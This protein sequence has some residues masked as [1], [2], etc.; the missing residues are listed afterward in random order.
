MLPDTT[1]AYDGVLMGM[2]DRNWAM[3]D[4]PLGQAPIE[5]IQLPLS[6]KHI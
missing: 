4:A 5:G 1:G 3:S 2:G 6:L